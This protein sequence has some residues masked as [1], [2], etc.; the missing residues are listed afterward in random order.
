M[1]LRDLD[2]F[3]FTGKVSTIGVFALFVMSCLEVVLRRIFN[4]PT[5]WSLES[6]QMIQV[7]VAMIG[8]AFCLKTEHHVTMDFFLLIANKKMRELMITF[9]SLIGVSV[10]AL[11]AWISW[12][13]FQSALLLGQLSE[14]AA[15]PMWPV[16]LLLPIGFTLL[17]IQFIV[18]ARNHFTSFRN[19]D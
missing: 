14:S 19:D 4:I 5:S 6:Q 17:S 18:R 10:C 15:I 7:A 8:A 2:I 13:P 12:M 9:N 11:L 3:A 16:K 1:F